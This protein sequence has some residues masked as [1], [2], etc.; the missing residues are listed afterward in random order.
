VPRGRPRRPG[1][2][3]GNWLSKLPGSSMW[4]RTWF[5]PVSRQTRRASLGTDD[6][7]AAERALAE[8]ITR[9]VAT[10]HAAPQDI[11]VARVFA[12][13]Y[14]RRGRHTIGAGAQ[15]LS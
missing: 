14:E 13:Y 12:R 1:E 6:F 11:T 15:Q 4:C 9:H 2:I 8:W 5:D 10:R 3:A 7:G